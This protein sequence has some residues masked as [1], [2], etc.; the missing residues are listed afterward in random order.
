M[1]GISLPGYGSARALRQRTLRAM[2]LQLPP[3]FVRH[4]VDPLRR[5]PPAEPVLPGGR[6]Q[7]LARDLTDEHTI[8]IGHSPLR[9]RYHYNAVENSILEHFIAAPPPAGMAVLDVGAGAGHWVDFYRGVL[10]AARVVA[11]EREPEVAAVLARKYAQAEGVEVIAGDMAD[12]AVGTGD[13]FD[14]V[15]AIG[16]MFHIV[17]DDRWRLAAAN[18]AR[19]LRPGGT[20]LVGGQFGPISHDVG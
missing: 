9:T 2:R 17:E 11:V 3:R 16:V 10:G 5:R 20:M 6:P 13:G 18:M 14:V 15:N 8:C 19:R 12:V 7:A 1:A 4:Y